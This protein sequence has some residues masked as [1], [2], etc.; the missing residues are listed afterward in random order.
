M[1]Q[2]SIMVKNLTSERGSSYITTALIL[3]TF[4]LVTMAMIDVAH[5]LSS[6]LLAEGAALT[7]VRLAN[8]TT[9][10]AEAADVSVFVKSVANEANSITQDR[11]SF[12]NTAKNNLQRP[13]K[14]FTEKETQV[15]NL[16]F[17]YLV[18]NDS[19]VA[20]PTPSTIS[21]DSSALGKVRN[22]SISMTEL[23]PNE[24]EVVDL[25]REFTIS[26]T[27]PT[28]LG[29]I[30]KVVGF[31][32]PSY[33]TV[34]RSAVAYDSGLNEPSFYIIGKEVT[35]STKGSRSWICDTC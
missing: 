17:G 16:V 8:S 15:F 35:P 4:F 6:A 24:S 31:Q 10:E 11:A 26:C 29:T 34:S 23:N 21:T 19:Q 12:W 9:L 3:P 32:V 28:Y 33:L 2:I 1:R 25:D 20:F 13:F 30:A 22:C 27:T 14:E 7:A 18:S 5:V